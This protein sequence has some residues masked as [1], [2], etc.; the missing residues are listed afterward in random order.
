MILWFCRL[1]LQN[2]LATWTEEYKGWSPH[3]ARGWQERLSF[4]LTLHQILYKSIKLS[5]KNCWHRVTKLFKWAKFVIQHSLQEL[6]SCRRGCSAKQKDPCKAQTHRALWLLYQLEP[7]FVVNES[8]L[9]HSQKSLGNFYQFLVGFN[10]ISE[11][12][13][14]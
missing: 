12:K 6:P 11:V 9:Y 1:W 10:H 2:P 13:S 5:H 14:K 3:I 7:T 8:C 4:S